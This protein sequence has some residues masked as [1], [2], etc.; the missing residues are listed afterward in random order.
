[1]PNREERE[2]LN[3]LL[4][5]VQ[6]EGF[7][8]KIGND[9]QSKLSVITDN[10]CIG[11]NRA[12]LA[13][14]TTLLLKKISTPN[15]D[16]RLHQAGFYAG[17]SGRHLDS[18]T[19]TP[20]LR[21]EN[22]PFMQSGS[23]W[24]TRSLEQARP[25][26]LDY[27]GNISP[28]LLKES[29]LFIVNAVEVGTVDAEECLKFVL[30]RLAMWRE[31]NA[32]L[33]LA[34]PT[35]KR[36]EDIVNLVQNHWNA[37]LPGAPRLPVLA[38]YAVYHCL[39]SEMTKYKNCQMLELLSHTSADSKTDRFGDVDI[40]NEHSIPIESIEIKYN[41]PI[42]ASMIGQLMEKIAGSGLKT[43]YVLST[44]ETINPKEMTKITELLLTI[45]Q[46]YGC[47][48][49]VN[50]VACTIRYYLRLL[51]DTDNYVNEYVKL[52]EKELEIPYDLKVLWN[53]LVGE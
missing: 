41:L 53:Q 18:T 31:N 9:Y 7:S 43:F 8:A 11:K 34:K 20:F 35:G 17:F 42:T 44:N 21:D 12:V 4:K 25:Y 14:I 40:I 23:G 50:G 36:I 51:S 15:Q 22:F 5:E 1:M 38:T 16:I 47:Q 3:A 46:K 26:T 49:I 45:R 29:F 2:T 28:P 48:V 27:P 10:A 32:S 52:V 13:V 24:L 37:G 30:H 6:L 19:V 39:L 33:T